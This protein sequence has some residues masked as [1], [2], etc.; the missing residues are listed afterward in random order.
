MEMCFK[1]LLF[2]MYSFDLPGTGNCIDRMEHF[3]INHDQ[4]LKYYIRIL[5]MKKI[6]AKVFRSYHFSFFE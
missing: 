4:T 3:E 1:I 2:T 5:Y 6:V